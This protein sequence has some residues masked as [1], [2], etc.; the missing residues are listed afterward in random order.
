MANIAEGFARRSNKELVQTISLS[1]EV[2]SR[3][4]IVL[5]Q[6]HVSKEAFDSLYK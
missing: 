6:G 3:L 1:A 2:Q 5:D 4:Y